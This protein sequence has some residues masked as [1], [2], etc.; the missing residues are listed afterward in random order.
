MSCAALLAL[1]AIAVSS[2]RVLGRSGADRAILRGEAGSLERARPPGACRDRRRPV[3]HAAHLRGQRA[4]RLLPPGLQ[5]RAATGSG[6]SISGASA[7]SAVLSA[8][9]GAAYV[10]Q[11]RAARLLP[12]SRR[13]GQGMDRLFARREGNG[14]RPSPKASTPTSRKCR[15]GTKPLPVEFKLT[16]SMPEDW[17]AED[18]LRIRSHALVSNVTSEV[19]R[20]RVVCAGGLEADRLRRKLDP[21]THKLSVPKGLDPCD[22]PA[23][24]L[25]RLHARHAPG[26]LRCR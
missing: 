11:D 14:R 13:H 18:V 5:R 19:A 25:A 1:A 26:Q 23:D 16:G 7:A 21:P 4:R 6:R 22:I 3:G 9:F 20:A 15:A 2:M 10:E 24:V 17:K 12:L 8:S